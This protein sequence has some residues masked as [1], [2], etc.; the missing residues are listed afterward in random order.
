MLI[1]VTIVLHCSMTAVIT[2]A[3]SKSVMQ[4]FTSAIFCAAVVKS[5]RIDSQEAHLKMYRMNIIPV[6]FFVIK[7]I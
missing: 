4:A 3:F 7:F 5:M 6:L 2:T 1:E